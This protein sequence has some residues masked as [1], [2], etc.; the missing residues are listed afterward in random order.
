MLG[1]RTVGYKVN[2][3]YSA[4]Q[5]YARAFNTDPYF[6]EP[7]YVGFNIGGYELGLQPEEGNTD[8][9]D[10]VIVYWGVDDIHAEYNRLI[11]LGA[12]PHEEPNNVGG[13]IMVAS[14][15]DPFGNI[16]GLIF[17]PEFKIKAG[18]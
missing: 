14:V 6:D 17:N 16:I 4:K 18:E 12:T 10:N 1:L 2:D 7:F 3:I 11:S 9:A 8:K 5:W 13:E 15:R